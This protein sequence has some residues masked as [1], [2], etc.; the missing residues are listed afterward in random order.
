MIVNGIQQVCHM[1]MVVHYT[2]MVQPPL[3]IYI[4]ETR[5]VYV[6]EM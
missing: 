2:V 6:K 1:K 4:D 3:D 5:Q